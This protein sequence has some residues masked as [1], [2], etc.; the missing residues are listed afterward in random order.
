[1]R[2]KILTLLISLSALAT[3]AWTA[4]VALDESRLLKAYEFQKTPVWC[5]AASIQLALNYHGFNISQPEIVKNTYGAEVAKTGNMLQIS[6]NLNFVYKSV[7]K[8]LLVSAALVPVNNAPNTGNPWGITPESIVNHLRK[9]RPIVLAYQAS[10]QRGHAVVLT[11]VEY[12]INSSNRIELIS[13][14]VRDP[15]PYDAEHVRRGG[16]RT[17]KNGQFPG[18]IQGVWLVDISET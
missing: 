15:F 5:W 6:N 16:V 7:N 14:T 17:Y 9:G 2:L 3:P 12:N 13:F 10:P 18:M 4:S 1:M 11:G 8:R